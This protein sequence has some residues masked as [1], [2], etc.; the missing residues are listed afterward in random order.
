VLVSV[1]APPD[2]QQAAAHG[3]RAAFFVVEPNRAQLQAIT[4]LIETGRLAP[5]VDRVL[6]LADTRAAYEA[7]RTEHRRGKVVIHVAG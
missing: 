1:V 7:L 3:V 6:S 4:R 2:A 5:A